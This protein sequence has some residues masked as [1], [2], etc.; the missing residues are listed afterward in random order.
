MAYNKSIYQQIK[1]KQAA[2]KNFKHY[3][4]TKSDNDFHNYQMQR[5]KVKQ[6]IWEAKMDHELLIIS[7]LKSNPKRLHKYVRQKQKVKYS[8]NPLKKSDGL[9][10]TTSEESA[11]ALA[12]FFKSVFVYEDLQ[13]LPDFPSRVSN[14]IPDLVIIEELVHHK[15]SKFN[16]TKAIGPDEIHPFILATFCEHLCKPLCLIYNQSL[17]SGQLPQD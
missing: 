16:T 8:I 14:A 9:T 17:Q 13:E 6:V 12:C 4:R 3:L 7:D 10:T 11:E 2:L 1:K 15:L 5:N